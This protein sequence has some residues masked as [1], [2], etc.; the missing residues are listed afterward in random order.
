MADGAAAGWVLFDA[1]C[2]MCTAGAERLS[3]AFARLG[4]AAAALQEPWVAERTGLPPEELQRDVAI[5]LADGRLLRGADA[6][7]WLLRR[8]WWTLPAWLVAAA[9]PTRWLFDLA[10]RLVARNRHRL[11]TACRLRPAA[12]RPGP[13]GAG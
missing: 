7:R 4:L 11:S 3:P 6:Y 1:S 2:G 9:P 5:L 12:A 13:P 10:Y 8:R